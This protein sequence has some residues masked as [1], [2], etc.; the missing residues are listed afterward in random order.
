MNMLV[1]QRVPHQAKFE[2]SAQELGRWAMFKQQNSH[3]ARQSFSVAEA[4]Q[5]IR[6][7]DW[8]WDNNFYRNSLL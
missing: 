7:P 8:E 4:L 3:M 1:G 2:P 5:E 6:S